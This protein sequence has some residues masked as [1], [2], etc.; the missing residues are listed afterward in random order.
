MQRRK[1]RLCRTLNPESGISHVTF[2]G[3]R[4]P[5]KIPTQEELMAIVPKQKRLIWE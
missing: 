2:I 1:E 5:I 3:Q 4:R